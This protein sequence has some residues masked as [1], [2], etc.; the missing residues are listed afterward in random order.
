VA[1]ERAQEDGMT[2]E[3]IAL[4]IGSSCGLLAGWIVWIATAPKGEA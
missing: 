1:L 3:A 2:P 4:C